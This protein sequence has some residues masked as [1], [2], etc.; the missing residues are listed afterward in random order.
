[1]CVDDGVLALSLV[2]VGAAGGGTCLVVE[3]TTL[4]ALLFATEERGQVSYGKFKSAES[5]WLA[6]LHCGGSNVA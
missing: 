3:S 1:M 6:M 2:P 5:R 4:R